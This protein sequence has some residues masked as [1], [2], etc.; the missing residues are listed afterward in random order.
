M[1]QKE[2]KICNGRSL[3][4]NWPEAPATRPD[5]KSQIR[6][7][8][9]EKKKSDEQTTWGF[10]SALAP[11]RKD[12]HGGAKSK[13]EVWNPSNQWVEMD[14]LAHPHSAFYLRVPTWLN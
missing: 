7:G 6:S 14:S 5:S 10:G 3:F 8:A 13:I 12:A 9:R 4:S 2:L 11:L 1:Q